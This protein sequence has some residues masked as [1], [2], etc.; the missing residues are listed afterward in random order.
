MVDKYRFVSKTIIE[1]DPLFSSGSL[2]SA[3]F[4][5]TVIETS[6]NDSLIE[7]SN[8]GDGDSLRLWTY[9]FKDDTFK[10]E[11]PKKIEKVG[12]FNIDTKTTKTKFDTTDHILVNKIADT[13]TINQALRLIN[14]EIQI[15]NGTKK[16]KVRGISVRLIWKNGKTFYTNYEKMR[17]IDYPKMLEKV[18]SLSGGHIIL[19][20]IW[21]YNLENDQD[22]M[23][24]AIAWK[25]K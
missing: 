21:Y 17:I 12:Y 2:T 6:S 5:G 10:I 15:Y 9:L 7:E 16:M 23:S 3:N 18:K 4:N 11:Y 19:D 1:K 25:I 20:M 22:G 24:G 14:S 13:I 8:P